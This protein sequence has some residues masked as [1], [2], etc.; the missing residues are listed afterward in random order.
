MHTLSFQFGAITQRL[1]G[2]FTVPHMQR[3]GGAYG[4]RCR[5]M[6]WVGVP[7]R[8]YFDV[9]CCLNE[10]HRAYVFRALFVRCIACHMDDN[11][12]APAAIQERETIECSAIRDW[13]RARLRMIL[14][15]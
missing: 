13:K 8:C 4:T 15:Q 3:D 9:Q 5:G 6:W 14:Q 1:G 11:Q 7:F 10:T 12:L 2:P